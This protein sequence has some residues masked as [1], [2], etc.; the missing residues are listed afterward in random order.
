MCEGKSPKQVSSLRIVDPDCGLGSF[1]LGA[2][3]YLLKW[4]RDYYSKES[5]IDSSK[6]YQGKNENWYLTIKEKKRILLNNIYGVDIDS[7]AVEVTKLS[8]L[9][10]VLEDEN[11]DALESQQ[12][13]FQERVLP[14]LGDNIKCGNSL[15]GSDDVDLIDDDFENINPF[16]WEEEFKEVFDNGVFDAVIGNPPYV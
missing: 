14:F 13:L 6:I 16:V 9:L 5:C 12:K 3:K 11:K 15:I 4:H 2:Y 10:K 7:Q 8:S 1:L